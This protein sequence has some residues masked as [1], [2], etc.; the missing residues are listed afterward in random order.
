M[1]PFWST[2]AGVVGA[3]GMLAAGTPAF[4]YTRTFLR[5]PPG[6]TSVSSEDTGPGCCE[7]QTGSASILRIL[8]FGGAPSKV[9]LPVISPADAD[10]CAGA[11]AAPAFGA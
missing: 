2:L 6:P 9:T 3:G 10:D 11:L 7:A 8:F 1:Q 5:P 4:A